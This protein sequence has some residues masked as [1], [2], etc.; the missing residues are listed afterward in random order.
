MLCTVLYS[1]SRV[2]LPIIAL[3]GVELP[4][5]FW[6][7]PSLAAWLGVDTWLVLVDDSGTKNKFHSFNY[8][9]FTTF[10]WKSVWVIS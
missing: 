3:Q 8:L 6:S 7:S 4:L 2:N 5:T 9:S 1:F 10:C